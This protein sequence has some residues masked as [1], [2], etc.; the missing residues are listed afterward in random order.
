VR[1][2][3]KL[4]AFLLLNGKALNHNLNEDKKLIDN[5]PNIDHNTKELLKSIK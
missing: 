5:D 1:E 3:G 4:S 2:S